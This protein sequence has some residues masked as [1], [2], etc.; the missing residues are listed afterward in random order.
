MINEITKSGIRVFVAYFLLLMLTRIMGRKMISQM[1]FFDFV[2]GV[3][4]GS[5]AANLSVNQNN[6]VVSGITVLIALTLFT[7]IL[8][9]S[10]IKSLIARKITKSE[11]VT[12][13]ENGRIIA[14]N[15]KR[16]RLSLDNLNMLLRESNAFN[17]AD[18]EFALFESDGKLSVLKKSQKAPVTPS[19]LNIQT[20]YI[21]LTKDIIIDGRIMD[22]NLN[23]AKLDREW[24][25]AKLKESGFNKVEDVFYAGLDTLGN[26]FTS[27]RNRRKEKEGQYGLE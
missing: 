4:V 5:V 10:D 14:E 26:L 1:T 18:V 27:S 15:L 22:E 19:D 6:Q 12:V 11:P 21:G 20:P 9:Y 13:I 3:I 2:V 16:T 17:I 7:L 25:I 24:L 23:D 8:D